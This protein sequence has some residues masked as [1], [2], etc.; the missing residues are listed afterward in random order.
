MTIVTT[1]WDDGD[2]QDIKIAN[3]LGR[4]NLRGTFYVPMVG[5]KGKK[6]VSNTDIK[7]LSRD[8][9]EIGGHSMSHQILSHLGRD[10][11]VYEVRD[12][13]YMLEQV[14]GERVE[15]FCYP[16]GRFD[17]RVVQ[18][19][20]DAGYQGARTTRMLCVNATFLPF[21][22]PTT[23]QAYPH[24]T[25]TY[26]RNLTRAGNISGLSRYLLGLRSSATWVELGKRL[27]DHVLRHGGV[28]H[29]YGHSWEIEELSIWK[30]LGEILDYVCNRP[31]VIYATNRQLLSLVHVGRLPRKE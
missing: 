6:I 7:A 28:W 14:L 5:F 22:M 30:Q 20:S 27:F 19:L 23:V 13:K 4:R 1:S 11:I 31:G 24:R 8:G 10:Q 12:C 25:S 2:P 15:L 26:I 21:E 9:F 29:L 17:Y 3:L 16:K 18:E